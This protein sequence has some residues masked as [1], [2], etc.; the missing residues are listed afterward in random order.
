MSVSAIFL[1]TLVPGICFLILA[2]AGARFAKMSVS[3]AAKAMAT[4]FAVAALANF[5]M[6]AMAYVGASPGLA[7]YAAEYVSAFAI[8]AGAISALFVAKRN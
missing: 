8:L 3:K 2:F 1:S 6:V 5:S 7:W 4:A